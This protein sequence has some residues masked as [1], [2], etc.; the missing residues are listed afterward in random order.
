MFPALVAGNILFF[1]YSKVLKARL[2]HN[3]ERTSSKKSTY[4]LF[5]YRE[6]KILKILYLILIPQHF[7]R[8]RSP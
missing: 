1:I 3:I 7:Y 8:R 5:K 4:L 6:S 2:L